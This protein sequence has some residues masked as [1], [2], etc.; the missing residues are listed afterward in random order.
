M[1]QKNS[2]S[3]HHFNSFFQAGAGTEQPCVCAHVSTQVRA[4]FANTP[5]VWARV[6]NHAVDRE[7]VER[8]ALP[9]LC[10]G[11]GGVPVFCR[12]RVW[13]G[14]PGF[15]SE[16][17][18]LL[19]LSVRQHHVSQCNLGHRWVRSPRPAAATEAWLQLSDRFLRVLM[20]L[21]S[22]CRL[23]WAGW[24]VLA[25]FHHRLLYEQ[26]LDASQRF[27]LWPLWYHSGPLLC[28]VSAA[29]TTLNTDQ[30]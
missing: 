3:S 29:A 14:F 30:E 2:H 20:A 6:G 9:H 23:Q 22:V 12:S 15:R 5:P 7:Q 24:T 28:N 16:V 25:C 27:P 10:H 26:L 8:A 11:S 4:I 17:G 13:M 19:Q 1:C 21:P 18:G